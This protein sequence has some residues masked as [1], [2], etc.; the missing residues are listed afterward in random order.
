MICLLQS[1]S[2][3]GAFDGIGYALSSSNMDFILLELRHPRLEDSMPA[4]MSRFR[5]SVPIILIC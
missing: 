5:F 3:S 4:S 2:V 1:V